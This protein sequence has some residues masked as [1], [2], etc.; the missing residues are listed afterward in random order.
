M[1]VHGWDFLVV[2]FDVECWSVFLMVSL[3]LLV[4]LG[5]GVI[6]VVLPFSWVFMFGCMFCPVCFV[7]CLVFCFITKIR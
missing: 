5:F 1:V 7:F 3:V 4:A 2:P 6:V